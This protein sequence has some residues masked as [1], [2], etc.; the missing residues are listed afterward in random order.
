MEKTKPNHYIVNTDQEL[1]LH[2]FHQLEDAGYQTLPELEEKILQL[3]LYSFSDL[4]N[5]ISGPACDQE[6]AVAIEEVA[7]RLRLSAPKRNT[8]FTSSREVG[9]YLANKIVGHKQEEFWVLYIDNGNHIVAEKKISQGTLDRSL[10]HPR[11]VFRWAVLFNCASIIVAHN[12]PSGK[13]MPSQSDLKLTDDL[14]KIAGLMKI[15]FL[16][17]F[18]LG[19]GH[20]LSMKENEL[21]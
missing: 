14:I 6:I 1:L 8:V 5:Y 15:N 7:D 21:F 18:I 13:M 20:Y 9:N 17:H 3:K 12:H 16:D 19:K 4:F 11:D 10:V 2:L